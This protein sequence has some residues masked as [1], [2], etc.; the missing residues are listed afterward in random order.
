MDCIFCKLAQEKKEHI[1]ETENLFAVWDKFPA[2][3]GHA[4]IIPKRHIVTMFEMNEDEG[5]EFPIILNKIK[6]AIEKKY[7]G[8][9]PSGYNVGSN[10][11][12]AA[13]QIVM[14]LHIHVLPRYKGGDGIQLL[15]NGEPKE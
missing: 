13:G 11:G 4:L 5:R 12:L 6:K 10:N 1:A 3:K 15:G 7:D 9:K 8:E 2:S 14:H